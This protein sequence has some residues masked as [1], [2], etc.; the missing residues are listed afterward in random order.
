MQ[1]TRLT[2]FLIQLLV[3]GLLC[4]CLPA[5]QRSNSN[6]PRFWMFTRPRNAA[7]GLPPP[8]KT[9]YSAIMSCG[10]ISGQP[11]CA[12]VSPETTGP[13]ATS[14][15]ISAHSNPLANCVIDIHCSWP[16]HLDSPTFF[17]STT[18]TIRTSAKHRWIAWPRRRWCRLDRADEAV[19][20]ARKLWLTGKSQAKQCDPVFDHFRNA[21]KSDTGPVPA[22]L[23][24]CYRT[25]GLHAR[26]LSCTLR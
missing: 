22:A 11:T 4:P 5:P 13:F 6:A 8:R 14:C 15:A 19:P 10:R 26:A 18:A 17:P 12:R 21:G 20:L 25:T 7:T 23:R 1:R 2:P 9:T 3:A 16:E 24:T